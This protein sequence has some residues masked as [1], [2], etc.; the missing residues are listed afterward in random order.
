M[1]LVLTFFRLE[2]INLDDD[3]IPPCV[4]HF[5]KDKVDHFFT[6]NLTQIIDV[7]ENDGPGT[8][9]FIEWLC[10]RGDHEVRNF[11]KQVNLVR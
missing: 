2:D 1:K 3:F 6:D 4:H 8:E 9:D 7:I 11:L 10:Q 5:V